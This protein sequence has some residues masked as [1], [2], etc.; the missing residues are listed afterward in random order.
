ML[1]AVS[2]IQ[3]DPI[4]PWNIPIIGGWLLTLAVIFVVATTLFSYL[5]GRRVSLLQVALLLLL[6]LGALFVVMLLLLRPYWERERIEVVPGKLFLLVDASRSM[7]TKDELKKQSRWQRAGQL[8][9]LKSVRTLLKRLQIEHEIDVQLFMAD[10]AIKKY[11]GKQE[12][13]GDRTNIGQWLNLLRQRAQPQDNL[14]GLIFLSDGINNGTRPPVFSEADQWGESNIPIYTVALGQRKTNSD[15]RDVFFTSKILDLPSMVPSKSKIKA[16]GYVDAPGF[17]GR[18]ITARLIYEDKDTK[19]KTTAKVVKN[20]V[21]P[22]TDRQKYLLEVEA[23]APSRPGEYKVTLKIDPLRDELKDDNNELETYIT[24]TKDGISVLWVEGKIRAYEPIF[25]MRY[26]LL[27]D[28]NIRVFYAVKFHDDDPKTKAKTDFFDFDK[29][30][31]DVI[32]IG[33]ISASRFCGGDPKVFT[34]IREQVENGTT[35]LVMLGGYE[36]FANSDWHKYPQ[37]ADLLPINV[38]PQHKGQINQKILMLPKSDYKDHYILKLAET[39]QENRNVWELL[40]QPLDGVPR[41][42]LAP[43]GVTMAD[44][45]ANT[46]GVPILAMKLIAGKDGGELGRVLSFAGDTTWKAWRRPEALKKDYYTRFWQ[47]MIRWLAHQET[48]KDTVWVELQSRRV[49]TDGL[50]E[51]TVGL[52]DPKSRKKIFKGTF[53]VKLE[54]P[55][56]KVLDVNTNWKATTKRTGGV[57]RKLPM[58]GDYKVIVEASG[59][60]DAGNPI[61]GKTTARFFAY[62]P[63]DI[64]NLRIA[65]DHDTMRTIAGN[66]GGKFYTATEKNLTKVLE[67]VLA[68]TKSANIV[69]DEV[70]PNWTEPPIS[71]SI[72]SQLSSLTASGTLFCFLVFSILVCTEW[73]FRRRWRLV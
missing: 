17:K 38:D 33:D 66:S 48:S 63:I 4:Y 49:P 14:R 72:G 20:I 40:F 52:R 18:Q 1:F 47:Q 53:D 57:I 42:V 13:E 29:N 65:T 35:G 56:G 6:R 71:T 12:P 23:D 39:P 32:V 45:G 7:S 61:T 10:S 3:F 67:T 25:A 58:P 27:R 21:L 26:G 24:V 69:K 54:C 50:P 30:H 15:Q 60:D 55:D 43:G 64:E 68:K 5:V 16:S 62:A 9:Q 11:D 51:F 41:A 70:W 34:R 36:T 2:K 37:I 59:K 31:Y 19:T 22:N 73:Y 8:L 44:D 46:N 28:P